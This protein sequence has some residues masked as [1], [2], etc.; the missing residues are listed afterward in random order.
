MAGLTWRGS[1]AFLADVD[2][3]NCAKIKVTRRY[4]P[5]GRRAGRFFR[6]IKSS[7]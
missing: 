6:V 1:Y 7:W 5:M 3:S 2:H 4:P